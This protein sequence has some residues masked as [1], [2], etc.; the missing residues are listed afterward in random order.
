MYPEIV[1]V[2]TIAEVFPRALVRIVCAVWGRRYIRSGVI[3][4]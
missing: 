2:S 3:T 4:R 1:I